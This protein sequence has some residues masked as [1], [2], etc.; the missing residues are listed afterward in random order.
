[1]AGHGSILLMDTTCSAITTK[2]ATDS[3]AGVEG[4][5]VPSEKTFKLSKLYHRLSSNFKT[6]SSKKGSVPAPF[7]TLFCRIKQG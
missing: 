4:G 6:I 5:Q 1:M 2:T 7:L 3:T